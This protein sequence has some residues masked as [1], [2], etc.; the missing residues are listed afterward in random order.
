MGEPLLR[1]RYHINVR[2]GSFLS[3]KMLQLIIAPI[4]EQLPTGTS[5]LFP[6]CV[7]LTNQLGKSRLLQMSE[8]RHPTTQGWKQHL[9]TGLK[10][11]SP[12]CFFFPSQS[13]FPHQWDQCSWCFTK[14]LWRWSQHVLIMCHSLAAWL[15]GAPK[16]LLWKAK[17]MC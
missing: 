8:W 2:W 17:L 9:H 10:F 5:H 12:C 7:F 3:P 11:Q 1:M 16:R 15:E 13:R 6:H 14:L 4:T